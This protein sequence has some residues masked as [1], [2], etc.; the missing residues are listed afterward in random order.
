MFDVVDNLQLLPQTAVT[1][2]HSLEIDLAIVAAAA[3]LGVEVLGDVLAARIDD[4]FFGFLDLGLGLGRYLI[5][6]VMHDQLLLL[7]FVEVFETDGLVTKHAVV[8]EDGSGVVV[9][10]PERFIRDA[11][12][13]LVDTKIAN[14]ILVI[15]DQVTVLVNATSNSLQFAKCQFLKGD[16]FW[17]VKNRRLLVVGGIGRLI[18]GDIGRNARAGEHRCDYGMLSLL[19]G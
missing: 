4:G 11:E 19:V 17:S 8:A 15:V 1:D 9:W 13:A 12:I 5:Q 6:G 14:L 10:D 2:T 18:F 16:S 3:K 7:F